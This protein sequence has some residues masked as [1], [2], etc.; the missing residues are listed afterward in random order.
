MR[1]QPT[2]SW[3]RAEPVE[4]DIERQEFWTR[5]GPLLDAVMFVGSLPDGQ[6]IVAQQPQDHRQVPPFRSNMS[7]SDLTAMIESFYRVRANATKFDPEAVKP[8][9]FLGQSGM[10]FDFVWITTNDVRRR[11]RTVTVIIDGKL[12]LMQ[13]DAAELHYFDASLQEFEAMVRSATRTAVAG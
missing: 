7:P 2:S 6:S 3:N 12:Y 1:V 9:T 11:G 5:N 4:G 13:F 10:Q 8:V